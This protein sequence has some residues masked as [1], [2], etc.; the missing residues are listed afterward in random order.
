M[1]RAAHVVPSI[2]NRASGPSYSVVELCR[3]LAEQ[4]CETSLYVLDSLPPGLPDRVAAHR[5]DRRSFPNRLGVSPAMRQALRAA[6]PGL[7]ILH[8]HSL[9]MM[10]NIYPAQAVRGTRCRL[11]VSPRGTLSPTALRRSR[12]MKWIAWHILGQKN[13]LG[14]AACFHATAP[15]ECRDIRN[16]G[17]R[18]PVAVIPNGIDVPAANLRPVRRGRRLLYLGRLHPIKGLDLLLQ[19]WKRLAPDFPDWDLHLAGPDED[20]TEASLR[21]TVA[22][23]SIPRVAF[24]GPVFGEELGKAYWNADL[25]VLPSRSENFAMSVAEAL[26]HGLPAVVSKGAPWPGL[27]T[28]RCGWWVGADIDSL[29]RALREA[30]G[31]G[32]GERREMG[33]RGRE[34]MRR[35][36]SWETIGGM[37]NRTYEWMLGGGAAPAWVETREPGSAA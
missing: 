35:D 31:A 26:A 9:W 10:P 5:F 3:S 20:G 34:W 33:E 23:L 17:F 24:D 22:G 12:A 15:H 18:Q 37:M 27:E 7:D 14:G 1:I 19:A 28:E 6:A 36:F 16:L 21:A 2:E 30:L 25:Y 4:G 8:N 32:D 11:V 13:L 29:E